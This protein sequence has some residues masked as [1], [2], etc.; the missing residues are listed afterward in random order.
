MYIGNTP[1]T[2]AFIPAIDYFS[3]NGSTVSFTLSRPVASVAQV[4]AVIENVPQSPTSAFTVSGNT[5]TFTSAPP[6][7]SNNIYVYY[8]SPVTQVIAPSQGTVFPS[9]LS[10]GG[11]YWDTSGNVGI[12]TTSPGGKLDVV[13]SGGTFRVG[14]AGD[15]ISFTKAGTNYISTTTAGGQILFQ[16]G[17][18][19]N[20][21]IIDSSGNVGIG[22]T[23]PSTFNPNASFNLVQALRFSDQVLTLGSYY[24]AGVDQYAFIRASQNATPSNAASLVFLRGTTESMR[25]DTSGNLLV[26]Q[27]STGLF[28]ASSY[29]FQLDGQGIRNNHGNGTPSGYAYMQFGYNGGSIGSIT[30]N[31]TTAVAY[32]T[33]SDYRLKEDIQP[34]TGALA[35]VAALKPVTYKWKVDGSDGEGFIAHELQAVVPQCVTGEKDAVDEDGNPKYQGIDTSF[36]V[37]TLTAAIQEQQ[38][39]ITALTARIEALENK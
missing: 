38:A 29:A 12:G 1:T 16:T 8:T 32:N 39:T 11:L 30:Q 10:T 23:S 9:S 18:S 34:M 15:V 20:A 22:T 3:G 5:I 13:G 6:S 31:G 33:S 19:S 17:A 37:A 2:V 35:R 21:A 27:T 24:Q 25:I 28:N 14:A 26:G 4:Q 7:G 36:L